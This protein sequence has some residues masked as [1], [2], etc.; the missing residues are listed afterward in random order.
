MDLIS[1]G[2][3]PGQ[4]VGTSPKRVRTSPEGCLWDS[5]F[6]GLGIGEIRIQTAGLSPFPHRLRRLDY[7][8]KAR[9]KE[10]AAFRELKNRFRR[11]RLKKRLTRP[12]IRIERKVDRDSLRKVGVP[13][14]S[15]WR[16][17]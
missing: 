7:I 10:M 4:V 8:N 6:L 11:W 15:G 1:I 5:R 9:R 3:I 2:E 13:K 14:D 17:K 12:V 16:N